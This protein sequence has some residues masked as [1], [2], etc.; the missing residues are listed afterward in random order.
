MAKASW[1]RMT[2]VGSL[3]LTVCVGC[4][5]T[6]RGEDLD[7][8]APEGIEYT[9]GERFEDGQRITDVA[10]ENVGFGYDSFQ[11]EGTEVGK[12]EAVAQYMSREGGVRLIVEGNCDE[13]GSREYNLSL[14]EHRAL[15]VRAYLIGLGIEGARIQTRSY[16]EERP[17]DS[18]H[19]ESAWRRNRRAE[20]ALYR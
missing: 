19:S 6:R 16:G 4:G 3:V 15:A 14:G 13:R 12:I 17:L 18:G 20:F 11:I 10:F 7:T 8:I 1:L 9:L 5:T 2:M